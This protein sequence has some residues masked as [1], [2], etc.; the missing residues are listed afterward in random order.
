M[1]LFQAFFGLTK[2]KDVEVFCK[3]ALWWVQQ[4][5]KRQLRDSFLK[6]CK[7]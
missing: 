7:Q 4:D 1:K 2:K 5:N 6:H 3:C